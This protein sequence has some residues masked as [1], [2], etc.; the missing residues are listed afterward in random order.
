MVAILSFKDVSKNFGKVPVLNNLNLHIE[1]NEL[2]GIV[3][4]SGSGKSTLLKILAGFYSPSGGNIYYNGE[5]VTKRTN[6]LKKVIG[7]ATQDNAF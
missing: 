6:H 2:F 7:F 3:G 1:K 5:D 4:R